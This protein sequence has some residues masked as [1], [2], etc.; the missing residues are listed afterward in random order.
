MAIS[1]NPQIKFTSEAALKKDNSSKQA[2]S[3]STSAS[4]ETK[5]PQQDT[6]P[7]KKTPVRNFFANIAYGWINLSEGVRGVANGLL[8]GVLTGTMLGA[9]DWLITGIKRLN[10]N[11]LE[12]ITFKQMFTKPKSALSKVGKYWAPAAAVAMFASNLIMAR[13]DANKRTANVDHQL[14]TGHRDK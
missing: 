10:K 9:G 3:S 1:F 5:A 6:A 8:S 12:H 14:Y 4:A 13:L 11:H 7:V 2:A